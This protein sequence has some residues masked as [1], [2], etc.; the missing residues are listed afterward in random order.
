MSLHFL[1]SSKNCS[2][3]VLVAPFD[4]LIEKYIEFESTTYLSQEIK[5][6][7]AIM[8]LINWGACYAYIK[9]PDQSTTLSKCLVRRAPYSINSGEAIY[10]Q[11]YYQFFGET[12]FQTLSATH[13]LSRRYFS[14]HQSLTTKLLTP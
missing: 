8:N 1:L 13:C 9:F 3:C 7:L 11:L 12:N 14:S 6:P 4:L 5:S 2:P 10:R